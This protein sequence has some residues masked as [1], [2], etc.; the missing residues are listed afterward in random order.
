MHLV[1]FQ[2]WQLEMQEF[3]YKHREVSPKLEIWTSRKK[4]KRKNNIMQVHNK[5]W[6]YNIN[7]GIWFT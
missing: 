2:V 7:I 3:P 6:Q 1:G 5:T 4:N